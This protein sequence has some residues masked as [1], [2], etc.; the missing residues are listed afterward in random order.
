MESLP[1]NPE[2]RINLENFH[3]WEGQIL[4]WAFI[5]VHVMYMQGAVKNQ[6]I[7]CLIIFG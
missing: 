7:V 4:V 1:Q 5:Y 3:P 6:N 2:F